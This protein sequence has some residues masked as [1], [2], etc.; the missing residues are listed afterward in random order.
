MV[1]QLNTLSIDNTGNKMQITVNGIELDLQALEKVN[2]HMSA[3]VCEIETV[4]SKW[5]TT[6][7]SRE[8]TA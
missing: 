5:Y 8:E 6:S 7:R 2:I 1:E 3:S 4:Y